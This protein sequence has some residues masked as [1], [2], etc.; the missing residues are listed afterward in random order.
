MS[1]TVAAP[2]EQEINGCVE[3]MI[4]MSSTSSSNGSYSLTV[5]SMLVPIWIKL[6]CW[7][8]TAL[9]SPNRVTCRSA[10]TGDH[11]Q[12]AIDEYPGS[13]FVDIAGQDI[14]QFVSIQLCNAAASRRVES[15]R[16][17]RRVTISGSGNYSMRIWADP[18][19][20]DA[21]GLTFQ[22]LLAQLRQQNVQV[23]A[24]QIGSP[25]TEGNQAFQY[26]ITALGRLSEPKNSKISLSKWAT[27]AA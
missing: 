7:Y 6:R 5:T 4:Y 16:R 17:R 2:L 1:E 26:T 27:M 9:R 8:R 18:T 11:G 3:N 13:R 10:S 21:R 24:G 19:M 20:L 23:A 12:E 14:R 15:R 22:D 25:P